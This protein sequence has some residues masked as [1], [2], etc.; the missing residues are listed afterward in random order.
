MKPKR[1][2]RSLGILFA[3]LAAA[4]G[5]ASPPGQVG[6]PAPDY[7]A[8]TLAGDS[9]ALAD[10][11]GDAV[12]LNIWATWCPPCRE[13]IPELQALHE[14]YAPRGLRVVGVS[15][16]AA[17]ADRTV[18]EFVHEFG[19]D[20]QILRDPAERVSVAFATRG[21]PTTVLVGPEGTVLWRHLGPIRADDPAL[22]EAI[23][24]ALSVSGD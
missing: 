24:Q 18:R 2:A 1:L 22:R 12:L 15:V 16:D 4:C 10:W 3:G 8:T 6:A 13:E 7:A 14:T 17:G 19:V 23:D 9:V 11:R 21:V 20:Y 5:G